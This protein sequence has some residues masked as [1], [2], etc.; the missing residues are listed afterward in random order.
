MLSDGDKIVLVKSGD[1]LEKTK[2]GFGCILVVY[3]LGCFE[4]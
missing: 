4:R 1:R 3:F 2:K